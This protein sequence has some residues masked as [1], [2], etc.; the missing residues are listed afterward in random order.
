VA[1]DLE[2]TL[3]AKNL[4][5]KRI[6]RT[7]AD[8]VSIVLYE[9]ETAAAVQKLLKDKYRDYEQVSSVEEGGHDRSPAA[10]EG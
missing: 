5:Y 9:K 10:D 7:G 2:D 8:K 6:S 3:S 4:R 1:T